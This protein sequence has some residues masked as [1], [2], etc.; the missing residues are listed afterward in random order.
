[1]DRV[2]QLKDWMTKGKPASFWLTGF[3]N[4]NGF[5]TA[6]M[7][8]VARKHSGWALDEV[9][10]YSEPTKHDTRDVHAGPEEGVYIHG[11]WID[12]AGWDKER[13][14]LVDRA[15]KVLFYELP[16]TLIT[17]VQF[18]KK[19]PG[20]GFGDTKLTSGEIDTTKYSAPLYMYVRRGTGARGTYIEQIDVGAGGEPPSKWCLRGVCL[21]C[22]KD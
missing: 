4:P 13:V 16:V 11:L 7:Q 15:S 8:D 14:C 1:M 12:G 20:W 9:A 6:T 18:T 22:I 17:G 10:M 21:L 3:F 19:R 2:Q 5:L